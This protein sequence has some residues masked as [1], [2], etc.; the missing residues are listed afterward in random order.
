MMS[1][2]AQ[3]AVAYT[4]RTF[5]ISLDYSEGSVQQSRRPWQSSLGRSPNR[6]W[7]SSLR[8]APRSGTSSKWRKCSGAMSGRWC[9]A[10]GGGRWKLESAAFPGQ[11]VI[12]LEIAGGGDIWP[13]F[14]CGKA[15]DQWS[16]GSSSG[17]L[18]SA[19]TEVSE[20]AIADRARIASYPRL[21]GHLHLH[22]PTFALWRCVHKSL[23][24]SR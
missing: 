14:N 16:R 4:Q 2:Y 6:R 13:H 12:T 23:S 7:A 11:Q 21:T 20:A 1:T 9:A 15:L 5:D 22:R 24:G 19:E 10:C 18:P 17:V 8:K 3:D